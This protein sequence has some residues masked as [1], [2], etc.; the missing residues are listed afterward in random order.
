MDGVG[1]TGKSTLVC[2]YL[3]S[4][5]VTTLSA[6]IEAKFGLSAMYNFMKVL[7]E[8]LNQ[9]EWQSSVSGEQVEINIKRKRANLANVSN[10]AAS[11]DRTRVG[12]VNLKKR[13]AAT[14]VVSSNTTLISGA[15]SSC[16]CFWP[17]RHNSQE[18]SDGKAARK[19]QNA[20]RK[21]D[22]ARAMEGILC[23]KKTRP[24]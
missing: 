24:S 14:T 15:F 6:N 9:A 20:K 10:T 22:E 21:L 4:D 1:G 16:S 5:A 23:G 19:E 12:V 13:S 7:R 8:D 3:P 11:M 18:V 17:C 2:A